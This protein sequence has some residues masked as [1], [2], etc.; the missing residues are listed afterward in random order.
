MQTSSLTS[1][2]RAATS[3]THAAQL[4]QGARGQHD[5]LEH[6][7]ASSRAGI[8][9]GH[10]EGALPASI[11]D[12][13]IHPFVRTSKKR[14]IGAKYYS[15]T[16][17]PGGVQPAA[18]PPASHAQR[19]DPLHSWGTLAVA[20]PGTLGWAQLCPGQGGTKQARS[21]PALAGPPSALVPWRFPEPVRSSTYV[22][23]EVR[24]VWCVRACL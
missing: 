2:A 5:H 1:C 24:V 13:E 8:L 4:H 9:Q 16:H 14:C 19:Q 23:A 12:K 22:C 21:A 3:S 15:H 6:L 17:T 11:E 20:R 7:N 18:A 10:A